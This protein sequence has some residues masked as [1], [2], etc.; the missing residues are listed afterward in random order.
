MDALVRRTERLRASGLHTPP[1]RHDRARRELVFAWCE[2]TPGRAA[3]R[4]RVA[5]T[6]AGWSRMPREALAPVL[7][8]LARLH[9]LAADGLELAAL[10]PWRRIDARL[11]AL[12]PRRAARAGAVRRTL[13]GALASAAPAD[14][15]PVHGDF[16]AGQVVLGDAQPWLLDLDDLGLGPPEADLGN[17]V[18]HVVTSE[19][20]FTGDVRDGVSAVGTIVADV[21]Q[22]LS[23]R[24][25][26][27]SAMCAHAAVALLRR[28][29]KLGERGLDD[30]GFARIVDA[31]REVARRA[32]HRATS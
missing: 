13:G 16:H 17:F 19:D 26:E 10:D 24:R 28:A 32:P 14:M 21:Y 3:L 22:G 6:G 15:R 5:R 11:G 9:A 20:L 23:G 2:G 27:T 25:C 4:E 12:A 18:A 1:A 29:L 7:E 31:A 30:D 8:P